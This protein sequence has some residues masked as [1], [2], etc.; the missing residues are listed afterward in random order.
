MRRLSRPLCVAG[1]IAIAAGG[2]GAVQPMPAAAARIQ[3][4]TMHHF[5]FCPDDQCP[6]A[7]SPASTVTIQVGETIKWTYNDG[8]PTDVPSCASFGSNCPG[9]STTS[10]DKGVAGK[11]L[12]DSGVHHDEGFPFSVTFNAPGTYKYYCVVHGGSSPN[13][14]LTHMD[15]TVI[16]Q[17]T[18]TQGAPGGPP[19]TSTSTGGGG[20]SIGFPASGA[21]GDIPAPLP[22]PPPWLLASIAVVTLATGLIVTVAITQNRTRGRGGP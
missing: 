10:V 11:P 16:V 15:G 6:P 1:L 14:P 18:G 8:D 22:A 12:W 9:H 19:L 7:T 21:V 20:V 13:N 5:E 2:S 4:V 3:V 17:G